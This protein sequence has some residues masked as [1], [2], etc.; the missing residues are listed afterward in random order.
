MFSW[1]TIAALIFGMVC[2][3]EAWAGPPFLTDDPEI[4]PPNNWEINVPFI[5]ERTKGETDMETPLFDINYG[6]PAVFGLPRVQ[7][8]LDIPVEVVSKDEGATTAGLGDILLGIK[9]PFLEEKGWRPMMGIYPQVLTPTGERSRGLGE[10]G[11]AYILPVL[12]EKNW[13]KWTVYGNVGYVVQTAEGEHN[14]WYEGVCLNREITERLELGAEITE[15]TLPPVEGYSNLLFN[16]GGTWKMSEHLNLLFTAG[17][18]IH[19]ETQFMAY[20]GIQML[21]GG[22]K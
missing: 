14:Y 4:P 1:R 12:A 6:T 19:G 11:A 3:T 2:L 9:W 15:N 8:E 16:F 21:L 13:D 22:T 17:H 20:L 18:S 7:L 10:G 5:L